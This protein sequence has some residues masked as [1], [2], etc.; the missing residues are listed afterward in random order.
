MISNIE[1]ELSLKRVKEILSNKALKEE[2]RMEVAESFCQT[3]VNFDSS[4]FDK[5]FE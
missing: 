3:Y 1:F 2:Y 4:K 5:Y